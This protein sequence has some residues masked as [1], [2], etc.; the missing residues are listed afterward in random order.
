MKK[1]KNSP[2]FFSSA[3]LLVLIGLAFPQETQINKDQIKSA[4]YAITKDLYKK[5]AHYTGTSLV[6]HNGELQADI[7]FGYHCLA[8]PIS[9][10]KPHSH[11]FPEILCFAGGNSLDI[12]DFSAEVEYTVGDEKRVLDGPGCISIPAGQVHCPISIKN[13]SSEKPIVFIE[14]SLSRTYGQPAAKTAAKQ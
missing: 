8:K 9:F 2:V 7:S 14:M 1:M 4:K 13:V 12:T 5:I 11:N 3:V 6:A 10:D